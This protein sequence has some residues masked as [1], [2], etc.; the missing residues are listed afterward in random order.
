M[1]GQ[2]EGYAAVLFPERLDAGP[3][4]LTRGHQRVE[5]RWLVVLDA[6][7]QDLALEH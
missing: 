4:H 1:V 6:R 3:D 2:I 7:R 5:H